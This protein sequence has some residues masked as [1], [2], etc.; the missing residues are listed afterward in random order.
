MSVGTPGFRGEE[1]TVSIGTEDVDVSVCVFDFD[2]TEGT[3]WRDEITSAVLPSATL[4]F[5]PFFTFIFFFFSFFSI[6]F[7]VCASLLSIGPILDLQNRR[8]SN[9][10]TIALLAAGPDEKALAS[11][12]NPCT[13]IREASLVWSS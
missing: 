7:F 5:C 13:E 4:S 1:S 6:S 12:S 9:R 10:S 2:E 3:G 11:T 8:V